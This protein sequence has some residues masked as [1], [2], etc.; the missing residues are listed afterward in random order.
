MAQ[1]DFSQLFNPVK[2]WQNMPWIATGAIVG[3][4]IY[5]WMSTGAI[6][7]LGYVAPAPSMN[8]GAYGPQ[9]TQTK[10]YGIGMMSPTEETPKF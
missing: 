10:T 7:G 5:N 2:I 6:L 8:I 4:L 9:P 1:F 3:V